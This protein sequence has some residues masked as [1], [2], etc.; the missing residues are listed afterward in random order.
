MSTST[1]LF[2]DGKSNF[3]N[4]ALTVSYQFRVIKVWTVIDGSYT[5]PEPLPADATDAQKQAFGQEMVAWNNENDKA[6]SALLSLLHSNVI[7]SLRSLRN[8][9]EMWTRLNTLFTK[10]SENHL[11]NYKRQLFNF[12][13]HP[14]ETVS[15]M[16]ARFEEICDRLSSFDEPVTNADNKAKHSRI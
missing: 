14:D 2:F 11:N 16:Q 9:N 15:L 12:K 3:R 10:G 7:T 6:I 4:W 5:A 1:T 13:M 8:A